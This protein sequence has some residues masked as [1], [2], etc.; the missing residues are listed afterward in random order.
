MLATISTPELFCT[1]RP[2]REA[3][4]LRMMLATY[5]PRMCNSNLE[6]RIPGC[7]ALLRIVNFWQGKTRK[8]VQYIKHLP[9]NRIIKDTQLKGKYRIQSFCKLSKWGRNCK[10]FKLGLTNSENPYSLFT[11]TLLWVESTDKWLKKNMNLTTFTPSH[12]KTW[13]A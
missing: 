1:W 5:L 2:W 4:G 10:T 9:T 13:N 11:D 3:L 6:I 8:H 12:W 7:T